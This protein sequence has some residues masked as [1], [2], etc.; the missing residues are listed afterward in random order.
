[1]SVFHYI[2]FDSERRRE[3]Y[4]KKNTST[5]TT[6][7]SVTKP[8]PHNALQ[9]VC[10]CAVKRNIEVILICPLQGTNLMASKGFFFF[11]SFVRWCYCFVFNIKSHPPKYRF[12]S[13]WLK[14][15]RC[16]RSTAL[17]SMSMF[18]FVAVCFRYH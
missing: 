2:E 10:V 8:W 4:R 6:T 9:S 14:T 16:S 7:P 15:P 1:M 5:T 13:A 3:R 12:H 11:C 18:H 17:I